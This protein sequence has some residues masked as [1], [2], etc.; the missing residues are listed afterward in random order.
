MY[1]GTEQKIN[2]REYR[3]P[4]VRI[5]SERQ[6]GERVRNILDLNQKDEDSETYIFFFPEDTISIN[7][8]YFGG[9]FEESILQLGELKVREKYQFCYEGEQDLSMLLQ[10]NIEEG[11]QDALKA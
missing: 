7:P 6:Y 1:R 10:R 5:F 3:N 4:G 9:L 11:I 8:S 2:V